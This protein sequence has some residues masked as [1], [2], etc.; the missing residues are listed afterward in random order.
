MEGSEIETYDVIVIG[1]G[2]SGLTAASLMAKRGLHV[3]VVDVNDHPG[4]S[5]GAFKR[6]EATFDQGSAM[7]FGFGQH[8]FNAHRFVF[9][10]LEEP[11]DMIKHDLLYCVNFNGHRI[12]FWPDVDQFVDELSQVFPSEAPNIRR[13]YSDLSHMY[14]HVIVENPAYTS[15]DETDPKTALGSLIRHPI[16][17]ARFI[18]YL[19]RSAKW[20]L[21]KY[22][23]DPEIFKFY[24]KLTSTYCYTNLEESPAVLAAVMFVDNHIGGSYYPAGSTMFLPGKLEKV[25]EENGGEMFHRTQVVQILF[26]QGKPSGVLLDTGETL[27]ATEIVYSGTMQNLYMHLIDPMY[28]SESKLAWVKNL[29]MTYPSIV[30]YAL[31]DRAVIPEDTAP[32]EMLAENPN[33][34]DESEITVYMFSIDDRT[35]CPDDCHTVIAIGPSLR[36]WDAYQSPGYQQQ[37]EDETQRLIGVLDRRFPGFQRGIRHAEVATPKTIERYTL[38]PNGAVAG[39]KQMIGQHM[40]HRQHI[41]TEWDSLFCC[42]EATVMGTGTP[43]VTTSGISAANA[44]LKKHKQP[45]FSYHEHMKDYVSFVEKPVTLHDLYSRDTDEVAA[46]RKQAAHCQICEHPTCSDHFFIAGV[47]RRVMVGNLHGA[48]TAIQ[49]MKLPLDIHAR[50]DLLKDCEHRCIQQIRTGAPVAIA[51]VFSFLLNH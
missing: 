32:V 31:V 6:G 8:G 28:V 7:L 42:G 48:R 22:F 43:A 24:D 37:K 29:V 49:K 36:E 51:E 1:A 39:P 2:L 38:K 15:P 20:L 33:Q 10:C 50:M 14:H 18:G 11:I 17:Y 12:R 26:N 25:I 47:M 13:F 16:S 30:L 9:N 45:P 19:N 41:R 3:A 44:V 27:S 34:L 4:G 5:C 23:R 40:F 21:E 46:I 35:L